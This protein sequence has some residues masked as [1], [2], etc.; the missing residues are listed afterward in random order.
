[1]YRENPKTSGSGILTAIPQSGTCPMKCEDCFFQSGR[2]YLEPLV[3]NL[4]NLP[5][6]EQTMGRVIRMNDGNDS[7]VQREKVLE[8]SGDYASVFFNTSIPRLDFIGRSPLGKDRNSPVV[9]TIN[10]GKMTEHEFYQ[11]PDCWF[12]ERSAVPGMTIRYMRPPSNL[13]FVR[14]RA[15]W[16]NL[17][18]CHSAVDHWT[19]QGV[20]VV[21]TFMAY[22]V[23]PKL[24]PQ[25]AAGGPVYAER[26]RTLNS[27]WAITFEAWQEYVGYFA[28]N[29]LVYTCGKF[30]GKSNGGCSRCGNCIREYYNAM[31]R[32][33]G[34]Y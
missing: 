13:M 17:R 27:Y 30:E 21:L 29:P 26:T 6:H 12:G 19:A 32:L 3:E 5:N 18:L 24:L 28:N 1:M 34:D 8:V 15:S 22:H 33:R 14:F 20:P 31:E 2:S 25:T 10:P 23:A 7:N 9:L 4:P 11:L 16:W